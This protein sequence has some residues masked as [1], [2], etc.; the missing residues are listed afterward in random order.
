MRHRDWFNENL[1]I[2]AIV[3]VVCL[4]IYCLRWLIGLVT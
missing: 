3:A 1:L 4:V 2:G